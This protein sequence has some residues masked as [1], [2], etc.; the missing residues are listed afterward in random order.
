MVLGVAEMVTETGCIGVTVIVTDLESVEPS[1][2]RHVSVYPV[3]T[4]GETV[5]L[6]AVAFDP[7]QPPAAEHEA[8]FEAVHESWELPPGAMLDGFAVNESM[9]TGVD[10]GVMVGCVFA[11]KVVWH[12]VSVPRVPTKRYW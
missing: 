1:V 6:P 8:A 11:E 9:V 5:W 3:V 7:D 4:E 10:V 2:P 12:G